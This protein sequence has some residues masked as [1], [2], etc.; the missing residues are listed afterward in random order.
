V[1]VSSLAKRFAQQYK[2]PRK[3]VYEMALN[4]QKEAGRIT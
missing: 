3:T 4:I 1:R 2:L